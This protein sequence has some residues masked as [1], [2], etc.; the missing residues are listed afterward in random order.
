M[1]E[2]SFWLE[3]DG[4]VGTLLEYD[5]GIINVNRRGR[6]TWVSEYIDDDGIGI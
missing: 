6:I 1:E 5:V 4:F 3:L 2:V